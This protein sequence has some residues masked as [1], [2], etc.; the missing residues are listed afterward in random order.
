MK[1]AIIQYCYGIMATGTNKINCVNDAISGIEGF[2]F[3]NLVDYSHA[4]DGDLVMFECS[5]DLY[6]L[7]AEKG[8]DVYYVI[9]GSINPMLFIGDEA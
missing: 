6:D 8:G 4:E 9:E 7:V 2:S 1:Y 3:A 5:G